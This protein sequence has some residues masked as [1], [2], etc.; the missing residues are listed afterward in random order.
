[1]IIKLDRLVLAMTVLASS[2]STTKGQQAPGAP[3]S[4]EVPAFVERHEAELNKALCTVDE[5]VSILSESDIDKMLGLEDE[6][7]FNNGKKYYFDFNEVNV[8][9]ALKELSKVSKLPIVIDEN[10]SGKLNLEIKGESFLGTLKMILASNS[11]DYKFNGS[12]FYVGLNE[13]KENSWQKLSYSYRYKLLN[14][15]PTVVEKLLN[16]RYKENIKIDDALGIVSIVAPRTT[17]KQII[18]IISGIDKPSRQIVLKLSITELT[19]DNGAGYGRYLGSMGSAFGVLNG[20]APLQ[21]AFQS[22][23][24]TKAAATDFM[25]SIFLLNKEGHADLKASPKLLVRDGERAEFD[26]TESTLLKNDTRAVVS[27]LNFIET[28]G[29]KVVVIPSIVEN[30]EIS[31]TVLEAK[32]IDMDVSDETKISQHSVKTSVRVKTG[33]TLLLG[34]MLSKKNKVVIKKVPLLGDIPYL[35]WLFKS[36][37]SNIQ[38]VEV[39]FTITPEILCN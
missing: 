25:S 3:K 33:E 20:L 17:M 11:L 21:P 5:S 2:C 18:Q 38:N 9:A 7:R 16:A 15:E 23:V 27:K 26:S 37:T 19:D 24:L 34:G 10:V 35:G 4:V 14:I 13:I 32:S 31:L 22:A 1:M 12:Y 29:V 6:A 8:Q 39:V 30:D 28:G 36:E